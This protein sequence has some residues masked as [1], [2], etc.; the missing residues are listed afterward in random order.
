MKEILNKIFHEKNFDKTIRTDEITFFQK[1]NQE[2]FFTV[3]YNEDE[4]WTFFTSEKTDDI[5]SI[6]NELYEKNEDIK[7]NTSLII[8]V[9]TND[10]GSFFE[11]NKKMIYRI[12]EDE[13]YFRKFVVVYTDNSIKNITSHKII[14]NKLREILLESDR[15]EVFEEEYYM[16]E[17][18]FLTMQLY[19]KLSFLTYQIK[20]KPFVS[21]K[22]RIID[23]IA[24]G[25]LTNQYEL[26]R[27]WLDDESLKSTDKEN[28]EEKDYFNEL[29]RSF[30]TWE[31]DEKPLLDFLNRLEEKEVED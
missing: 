20:D 16:D 30:L 21:I 9:K 23:E 18:F 3:S 2:Y 31:K 28:E 15:M 10:F 13:Y 7:K 29:E 1:V 27:D 4:L 8:Y 12:E 22:Q 19:V 11:K 6:Q 24:V 17:E 5:I 14:S 26:I 25:N